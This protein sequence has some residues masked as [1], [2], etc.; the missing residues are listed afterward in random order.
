MLEGNGSGTEM[1]EGNGTVATESARRRILL[2]DDTA[3]IRVMLRLQLQMG[4]VDFQEASS[5]EEALALCAGDPFDLIVLD[6]RMPGLTG[7]DVARKLRGDQYPSPIIMYSAYVD[8]NLEAEAQT[9]DIPVVDK[10][11]QQSL[12][13]KVRAAVAVS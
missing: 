12:R 2:V 7:I 13:E 8:Q 9:L 10:A 6:H 5:G 3:D 4:G 11:D 1:L